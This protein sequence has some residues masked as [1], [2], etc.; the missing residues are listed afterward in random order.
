MV[1]K[2][3]TDSRQH[4]AVKRQKKKM[5]NEEDKDRNDK[6][7]GYTKIKDVNRYTYGNAADYLIK[8]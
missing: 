7:R 5:E 2:H 3:F 1:R 4:S 6:G 8:R